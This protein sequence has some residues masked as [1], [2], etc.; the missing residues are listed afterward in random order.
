MINAAVL[1]CLRKRSSGRDV[2]F[3]PSITIFCWL[4]SVKQDALM[5]LLD[6]V[7]FNK[8]HELKWLVGLNF[9]IR[10]QPFLACKSLRPS[11]SVG[12]SYP[13]IL[14]RM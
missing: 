12:S 7:N 14:I 5:D 4:L 6:D 2:L 11:L 8:N 9:Q 3:L 13:V 1:F 10:F